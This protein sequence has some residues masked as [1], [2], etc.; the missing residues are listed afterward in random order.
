MYLY[1][2]QGSPMGMMYH[3]S[4]YGRG[5]FDV[6]WYE[7]NM[8][9]DIIAVY[10]KSG[11]K[12]VSYVYDAYGNFYRTLHGI[13]LGH[14]AA[15]NPFT[16]RG[17]YYDYNLQLYYVGTR[18]YD[19][20]IGRWLSVDSFIS[21]V[22]GDLLGYNLFAYCFNNPVMYTDHSGNWPFLNKLLN[23]VEEFIVVFAESLEIEIGFGIGLGGQISN[24]VKAELSRDTY[25]GLDDGQLITGN[26]IVA[27]MSLLDSD[28]SVGGSYNHLVEKGGNRISSSGSPLHGPFDMINYPDVI[29]GNKIA[30]GI[31]SIKE[32][33]DLVFSLSTSAHFIFGG[34]ASIGFN[35]SEFANRV[36]RIFR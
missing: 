21:D 24:S 14:T 36:E 31:A 8:Q 16:Y 26:T 9:G 3:S 28:I 19:S 23:K 6:Y 12:L 4:S 32:N 5:V 20:D 11:T 35:V 13:S 29:R 7:R 10:D 25:F 34:H 17:Y 1:D 30:V 2:S 27:E 33:N 22:G 15:N 18:Y